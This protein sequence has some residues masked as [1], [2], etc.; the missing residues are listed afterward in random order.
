MAFTVNKN[1]VFIISKQFMN[2]GLEKLV[3]ILSYDDFKHLS[4]EFSSEKL[5]LLKK[6]D[7]YP[8]EYMDSFE[9]FSEKNYLIKN[10]FI[11]L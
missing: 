2:S 5:K 4:Q 7:T 8:Y 3:K 1:L 9:R 10:I 11:S 6:K